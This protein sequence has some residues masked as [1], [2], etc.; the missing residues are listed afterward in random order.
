MAVLVWFIVGLAIW[1][2]TVWVPDRFWGGIVGALL[3]AATGAL[4]SGA[5]YQLASGRS[6]GDTDLVTVI[7]AVPGTL[8]G[9]ALIYI[10]GVRQEEASL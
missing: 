9:L 5:V 3:G 6:V 8:I 4:V 7:V 10:I 2:F 1:H